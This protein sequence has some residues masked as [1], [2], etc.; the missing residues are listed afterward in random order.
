[1]EN[2]FYKKVISNIRMIMNDRKLTQ[3]TMATYINK[4]ESQ[5]SKILAGTVKLSLGQLSQIASNLSMRE[6]DIITY[7]A[8]YIERTKNDT[9]PLEAILQIRLRKDKKDQVLKLV[10]G[11]NNLEILNKL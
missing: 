11:E 8:Q 4:T 5:F 10:F 6:I 9:E 3:A 7:P 1:M 2:E